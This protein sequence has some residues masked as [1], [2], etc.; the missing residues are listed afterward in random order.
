[1][2]QIDDIFVK[3]LNTDSVNQILLLNYINEE[4]YLFY[5]YL[6]SYYLAKF[7]FKLSLNTQ[8]DSVDLFDTSPR[9]NL[10]IKPKLKEMDLVLSSNEK[11]IIFLEYRSYVQYSKKYL[12][13]NCY[14]YKKDIKDFI[15]ETLQIKN[16]SLLSGIENNPQYIYSELSKYILN[17]NYEFNLMNGD[18]L[19]FIL[20]IRKNYYETKN[21]ELN[22]IKL[23]DLIKSE[24][25]YKKFNFLT[26]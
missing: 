18:K 6:I 2:N 25:I 9:I 17:D 7:N 23:F 19:D 4:I 13:V 16:N 20:N 21:K 10:L 1:M 26:Y 24:F 11:S 22:L 12:S 15:I 3:F 14:N 5:E 8:D